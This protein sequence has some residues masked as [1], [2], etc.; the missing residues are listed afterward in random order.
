MLN[1]FG[2]I[3]NTSLIVLNL[4]LN[5]AT[6]LYLTSLFGFGHINKE[7]II[8]SFTGICVVFLIL[9]ILIAIL[10]FIFYASFKLAYKKIQDNIETLIKSSKEL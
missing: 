9:A 7:L 3:K 5:I 2:N 1:F 8:S 4:I 6:I 10:A